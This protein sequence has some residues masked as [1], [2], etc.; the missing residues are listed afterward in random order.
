MRH[1]LNRYRFRVIGCRV[2]I[3]PPAPSMS[4][5]A[6]VSTWIER[7]IMTTT[8]CT[9]FQSYF[10][11]SWR[12]QTA[13]KSL[14]VDRGILLFFFRFVN[15]HIACMI[16]KSVINLISMSNKSSGVQ[17]YEMM[18]H[19]VDTQWTGTIIIDRKAIM[20]QTLTYYWVTGVKLPEVVIF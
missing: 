12:T 1:V 4:C 3:P 9:S 2:E 17:P 7:L 16:K 5:L 13:H 10:F 15:K 11:P 18:R 8:L 20:K 19:A 6:Q 14:S